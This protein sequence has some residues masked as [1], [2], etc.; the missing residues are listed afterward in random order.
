MRHAA[1]AEAD[2]EAV[3]RDLEIPELVLQDDGHL[4]RVARQQIISERNAGMIGAE[5]DVQVMAPGQASA[6]RPNE[7]GQAPAEVGS[8]EVVALDRFRKK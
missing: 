1:E 4:A 7:P 2:R 5:R 8:A 6:E 3:L